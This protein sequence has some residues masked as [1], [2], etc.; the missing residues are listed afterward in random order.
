MIEVNLNPG[1]TRR[2]KSRAKRPSFS[3][4]SFGG[5]PSVDPWLI[6]AI[7][8]WTAGP[9]LVLWLFL[10]TGSQKEELNLSIEQAVQDSTRYASIIKTQESLQARRD[11]IAQKL[12][13]IQEI[14]AGRYVWPHI[15][16]E[17]SRALPAYT[18]LIAVN[19]MGMGDEGSLATFQVVGRTGNTFALTQFMKDLEASPFIRGVQLTTT[20]LVKDQNERV[21]HEF[22]L[23]AA[24]EPPPA[25]LIET[26]PLFVVEN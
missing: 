12:E 13:M 14:D 20:E 9:G 25:E 5:G 22:I 19:P 2:T 11:T 1:A 26:V 15:L 4:P 23:L 21:V 18:W 10:S 24:Y 6:F 3:L 16:D 8:A 17:V 7:L